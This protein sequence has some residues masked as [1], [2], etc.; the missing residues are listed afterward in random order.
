[1]A[2]A[3]FNPDTPQGTVR[4]LRPSELAKFRAHLLRLDR[5]SRRD[6]FNGPSSD[7]FLRAYAEKCFR[8]GAT[9][10]GYVENGK[11]LGAAEL[12]ELAD[13]D[14]PTAEIAF[15]VERELQ[16]RGVGSMLFQRLIG[17][18]YALGYRRLHVTTHPQNGA[19]RRLAAKFN[20]RLRFGAGETVGVIELAPDPEA[21]PRA[22][23]TP[24]ELVA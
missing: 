11:V 20:A 22:F 12:H 7:D 24:R 23:L 3:T 13:N 9:V 5:E 2:A 18:A 16:H 8:T 10:V 19:M 14:E 1:M 6:R 4:Q 15:S 17:H 21:L